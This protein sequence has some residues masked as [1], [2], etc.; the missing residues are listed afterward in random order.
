MGY[1][2]TSLMSRS[3]VSTSTSSL[4]KPT[5]RTYA[6]ASC[7]VRMA[8]ASWNAIGL[9]SLRRAVSRR[10]GRPTGVLF[11]LLTITQF[12]LPFWMSRTL[13]NMFALLPGTSIHTSNDVLPYPIPV[14]LQR[15]SLFTTFARQT[16]FIHPKLA[17]TGQSAF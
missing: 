6:L 2:Q 1:S 10:F 11:V 4:P 7:S 5:V 3:F 17:Y 15:T 14:I 13:P 8:L 9:C 12:H 16:Q